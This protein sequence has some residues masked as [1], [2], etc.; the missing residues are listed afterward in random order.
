LLP[1]EKGKH[2]RAEGA[3]LESE[4]ES[5]FRFPPPDL[6]ERG[7]EKEKLINSTVLD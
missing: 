6:N 5:P 1:P 7:R 2:P 4:L 3:F